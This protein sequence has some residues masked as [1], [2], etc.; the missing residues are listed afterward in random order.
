MR[1]KRLKGEFLLSNQ[2]SIR[3]IGL[4]IL[5]IYAIDLLIFVNSHI[6]GAF[7]LSSP[8]SHKLSNTAQ[9]QLFSY[10]LI[11]FEQIKQI[12]HCLW[13]SSSNRHTN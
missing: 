3:S 2:G 7:S 10:L 13:S 1:L 5:A 6:L 8:A 4:I 9:F 11:C 12:V